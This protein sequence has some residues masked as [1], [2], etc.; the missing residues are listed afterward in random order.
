MQASSYVASWSKRQEHVPENLVNLKLL[1]SN[2]GSSGYQMR[3]RKGTLPGRSAIECYCCL[4]PIFTYWT[5]FLQGETLH[6]QPHQYLN[7][8]YRTHIHPPKLNR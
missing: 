6:N 7:R 5:S 8:Y 1:R 2:L 3:M 4:D